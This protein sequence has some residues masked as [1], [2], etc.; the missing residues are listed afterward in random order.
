MTPPLCV[1]GCGKNA[2]CEYGQPNRCICN[3]GYSGNP[4]ESCVSQQDKATCSTTQCGTNAQCRQGSRRV[5][6]VCP[7]G[8]R[9]NPYV[10]CTD[11]D[12]CIG[13]ACGMNAVCLNTLGS[14]DCRCEAGFNGNPFQMCMPIS[15]STEP[16]LENPEACG[17]SSD[18]ECPTGFKCNGGQ[19]QP[20]CATTQCGPNAACDGGICACLPGFAGDGTD[21]SLGCQKSECNNN[22]DCEYDEICIQNR[23]GHRSCVDA[24]DK[25][26][27]GPNAFC[28]A[29]DHIASCL[30]KDGFAGDPTDTRLGCQ[31]KDR[32][33][34]CSS[35]SDCDG[36]RIC[37]MDSSG[38]RRCADPC[39][40]RSCGRNEVCKVQSGR[41]YCTCLDGFFKNPSSNACEG[42]CSR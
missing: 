13:N 18:T 41:P 35:S 25:S 12:E 39:L 21:L 19:C 20:A 33:N 2:H 28:V 38:I 26:Q 8:F 14:Y 23:G 29:Q 40:S 6:C 31:P 10:E 37:L 36:G 27:C 17:C 30:C 32:E 22:L 7:I 5:D 11:V 4:Y 24:C 1:P 9:G 15:Q 42:K 3:T 34:W 16:C